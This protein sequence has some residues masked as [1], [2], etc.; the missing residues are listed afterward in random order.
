MEANSSLPQLDIQLT[1]APV[2][3]RPNKLIAYWSIEAQQDLQ[4]YHGLNAEVEI[5]GFMQNQI[6]RE[7]N[8][9]I[10]RHIRSVASAG[11]V[12]WDR[13]PPAGVQWLLHKETIYDAFVQLSNAIFTRTQ[14]MAGNWLVA[15]VNVCN[16]IETLSRFTPVS[17]GTNVAGIRKIGTLGQFDV[18]KDPAYPTSEFLMGFK[19]GSFLDTGYIWAPYLMLYTTSTIVLEDMRARKGM[20]QRTGMKVVNS[21]FYGTGSVV[22]TGGAFG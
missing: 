13:T 16:V 12:T 1:S 4:A 21:N 22:Q 17:T 9:K 11:T 8:E 10:V 19:G 15:G 5:V 7:I 3:A 14:R 6:A 20:M 18:Y 2:V